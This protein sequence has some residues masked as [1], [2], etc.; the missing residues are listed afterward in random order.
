M[1]LEEGD[2]GNLDA[3]LLGDHLEE[4]RRLRDFQPNIETDVYKRQ[5]TT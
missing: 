5:N 1:F 3:L 4:S 2:E